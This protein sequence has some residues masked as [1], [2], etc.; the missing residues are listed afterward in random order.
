M[1]RAT[2]AERIPPEILYMIADELEEPPND[3]LSITAS[4]HQKNQRLIL[5][6]NVCKTWELHLLQSK[7]LWRDVCFDTTRRS[8]IEMAGSFLDLLEESPF[9][10]YAASSPG[11]LAG[12]SGV[13]QM[14][15]A[16]LLRISQRA[17]DIKHYGIH[18]PSKEFSAHLDLP[19]SKLWY[20]NI[21]C[22]R[23]SGDFSGDFS[24]LRGTCIPVSVFSSWTNPTFPELTTLSLRNQWSSSISLSQI[25]RSLRGMPKLAALVLDSFMNFDP[26]HGDEAAVELPGLKTLALTQC[27]TNA[28]L[29]HL[30]VPDVRDCS[31]YADISP[32]DEPSL[33]Y[34]FLSGPPA[35]TPTTPDQQRTPSLRISIH[36]IPTSIKIL[37][38]GLV[39]DNHELR[40]NLLWGRESNDWQSWMEQFLTAVSTRF[41]PTTEIQLA[42]FLTGPVPPPLYSPILRI[43]RVVGM[44]VWSS[45]SGVAD[46][47]S[48]LMT[49]NEDST[50]AALPTLRILTISGVL[51]FKPD[52]IAVV[53]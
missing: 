34:G 48:S 46:I 44:S 14:A 31:I 38:V 23:V 36:N 45:S 18:T 35:K 52:E 7:L 29:S 13:Q 17:Q 20:L 21:D 10:V 16:L 27:D 25:L 39:G 19:S 12:D 47:L 8:T 37:S 33:I 51:F 15:K 50:L 1:K 41:K 22:T 42:L 49:V 28:I 6:K 9:S 40:L 43:P 5:M 2:I 11:D 3:G 24:V 32:R 26:D 53:Q 4:K 30:V